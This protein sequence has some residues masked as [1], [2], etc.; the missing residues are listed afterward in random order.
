IHRTGVQ[1]VINMAGRLGVSSYDVDGLNKLFGNN[2]KKINKNCFPGAINSALG[3]GSLTAVDQATAFSTLVS[4]G[5]RVTPHVIAYMTQNGQKLKPHGIFRKQVVKP[6]VAADADYALSFD[7]Q[8]LPVVGGGTGV[9]NAVWDRPMIAKT[10]TLGQGS[11]A[12]EAW[13]VGAIPQYS[14]AVGMFTDKP[15]G[16]PPQNLD[17]LPAIGG[18]G[19]SFGG[20]WPATIWHTFMSEHFS[21]LTVKDLPAPDYNG[22]TK[23]IQAKPIKKKKPKCHQRHGHFPFFGHG[24]GNGNGNNCQGNGNGKPNPNPSGPPTPNPPNS[25]SPP[26]TP[27]PTPTPSVT[28]TPTQTPNPT[29]SGTPSSPATGGGGGQAVKPHQL[30]LPGRKE[31]VPTP[32]SDAA[33]VLRTA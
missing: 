25:P 10:G 27:N 31:H 19:G 12:A 20:A 29:P 15:Y 23:W 11:T 5:I 13:F 17:G 8:V 22:F 7:T 24:H 6:A 18:I 33:A 4:G 1:Q 2:C 28:P 3:E 9:P 14:L 26:V 30:R 21:N 32:A 16:N